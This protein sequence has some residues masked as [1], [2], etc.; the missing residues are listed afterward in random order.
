MFFVVVF[1]RSKNKKKC[2]TI[3]RLVLYCMEW[4]KMKKNK[5]WYYFWLKW[6]MG[7]AS[8]HCDWKKVKIN[9]FPL[10]YAPA[11]AGLY[12]K[13]G[14]PLCINTLLEF[15]HMARLALLLTSYKYKF[16]S[17]SSEL[18]QTCSGFYLLW[19]GRYPFYCYVMHIN[20]SNQIVLLSAGISLL[21]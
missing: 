16:C 14:F 17:G 12:L 15:I 9:F 10:K 7:L 6:L 5:F 1:L 13:S 20:R 19:V 21:I 11:R 2:V 8:W 4:W 3:A 18:W